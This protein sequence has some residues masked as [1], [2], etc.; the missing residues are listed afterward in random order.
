MTRSHA[1]R[2]SIAPTSSATTP[3]AAA[4]ESTSS[5]VP[6][7]TATSTPASTITIVAVPTG[8]ARSSLGDGNSRPG[9][10][11]RFGIVGKS[12]M[13]GNLRGA[14]GRD[15]TVVTARPDYVGPL[16]IV[17]SDDLTRA[18]RPYVDLVL[19][20]SPSAA[21]AAATAWGLIPA[22]SRI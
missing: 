5:D 15:H 2:P 20:S 17:K 16:T 10:R 12:A 3:N 21:F 13:S 9:R 1:A 4:D 14:Q 8:R 6:A 11:A 22:T 7:M 18:P 19:T